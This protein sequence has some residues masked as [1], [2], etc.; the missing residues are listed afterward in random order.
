MLSLIC[1]WNYRIAALGIVCWLESAKE[2]MSR[3]VWLSSNYA[4]IAG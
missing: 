1:E 3:Y 2:G 4:K